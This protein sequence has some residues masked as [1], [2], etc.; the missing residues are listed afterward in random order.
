MGKVQEFP[1][2]GEEE[3]LASNE[4][5][6]VQGQGVLLNEGLPSADPGKLKIPGGDVPVLLG[7][8]GLDVQGPE[9]RDGPESEIPSG[10][11]LGQEPGLRESQGDVPH[12]HPP[13]D[14]PLLPF[15]E[16]VHVVDRGELPGLIVV[17]FHVDPFGHGP[18]HL[19]AELDV[20]FQLGE[21]TRVAAFLEAHLAGLKPGPVPTELSPSPE[22]DRD[23]G[24]F[25]SEQ[26]WSL[27]S[28]GVDLLRD[29]R[30]DLFPRRRED[31]PTAHPRTAQGRRKQMRVLHRAQPEQAA[32]RKGPTQKGP[33]SWNGSAGRAG[34]WM[35]KGRDR[36]W[37]PKR[38]VAD[39]RVS[40]DSSA[41]ASS[42]SENRLNGPGPLKEEPQANQEY[43]SRREG[44]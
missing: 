39:F 25:G 4:I 28:S 35:G 43:E 18:G 10:N 40:E 3:E 14:G 42:C 15:V 9:I 17:H 11:P 36:R 26:G 33:R 1:G 19:E 27:L 34:S 30:T 29:P 23:V 22:P 7:P 20:G 8:N 16:E 5:R 32:L 24:E 12:L 2:I 41:A 31:P 21:E 38:T 37:R 6:I 13:D 44:G